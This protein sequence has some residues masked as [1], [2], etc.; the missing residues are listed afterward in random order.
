MT[1]AERIAR[2]ASVLP[3]DRQLEILDFAEFLRNRSAPPPLRP[4]KAGIFV[5]LPYFIS[6]DFDD[7]LPEAF[8]TGGES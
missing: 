6:D 8:W 4:R 3:A 5:G 7:P 2:V 1:I